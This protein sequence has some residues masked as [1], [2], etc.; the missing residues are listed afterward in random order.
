[1]EQIKEL[2]RRIAAAL[3]RIG[4]GLEGLAAPSDSAV[5]DKGADGFM[6]GAAEVARLTEELE[7]ERVTAELAQE[8]LARFREREFDA[9]AALQGEIDR[10]TRLVDE[11]GI[12]MQRIRNLIVSLREQ[13]RQGREAAERGLSDPGLINRSVLAEMEAMR[14]TRAIEIAE[15]D[16]ILAELAPLVA[17]AEAARTEG[18]TDA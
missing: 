8:K 11:Q 1:M 9:R 13:L 14:A 18:A 15:M 4:R 2:E 6:D 16:A 7:A 10:L 5:M 3:D 17:A 12:E